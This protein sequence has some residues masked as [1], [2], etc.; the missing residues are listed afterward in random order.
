MRRI[1]EKEEGSTYSTTA[2]KRRDCEEIKRVK[3]I[4]LSKRGKNV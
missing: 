2:Q 3:I 4:S 1:G